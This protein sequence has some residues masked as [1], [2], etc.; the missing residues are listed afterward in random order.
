MVLTRSQAARAP[1]RNEVPDSDSENSVAQW[2]WR[3]VPDLDSDNSVAQWWRREIPGT[4]EEDEA[5]STEGKPLSTI[6]YP[7]CLLFSKC[8]HLLI[9]YF[10]FCLFSFSYFSPFLII[11]FSSFPYFSFFLFFF[12]I[13]FPSFLF[14][15]FLCFFFPLLLVDFPHYH[16][17]FSL[18]DP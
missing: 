6:S 5:W 17:S 8:L 10:L 13:F 2:W 16:I 1:R 18:L 4:D 12:P 3:E 11:S 7:F 14:S 15:S 9:P